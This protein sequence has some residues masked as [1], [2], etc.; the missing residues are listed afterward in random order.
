MNTNIKTTALKINTND[1]YNSNHVPGDLD[2][3]K[4]SLE[5]Y[6]DD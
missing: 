1:P 5:Y 3:L 2:E 4:G 6:H